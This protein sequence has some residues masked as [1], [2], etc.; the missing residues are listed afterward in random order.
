RG[1]GIGELHVHRPERLLR[2]AQQLAELVG[3]YAYLLAEL[4]GVPPDRVAELAHLVEPLELLLEAVL[5][6]S[7]R[8]DVPGVVGTPLLARQREPEQECGVEVR[9]GL[10]VLLVPHHEDVA[11]ITREARERGGGVAARHDEDA[12][13][14]EPV[15]PRALEL[16]QGL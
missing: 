11:A 1:L 3:A 16:L 8:L 15:A 13:A 5:D 6:P 12:A 2:L 9:V 4:F 14:R 10:L 7:E